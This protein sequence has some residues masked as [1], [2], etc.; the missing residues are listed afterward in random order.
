MLII[1]K[2]KEVADQRPAWVGKEATYAKQMVNTEGTPW[3]YKPSVKWLRTHLEKD[4]PKVEREVLIRE[5]HTKQGRKCL[6]CGKTLS[7]A[8]SR[9][10]SMQGVVLDHHHVSGNVRGVAH[11]GCNQ[12]EGYFWGEI[13][14]RYRV[15]NARIIERLRHDGWDA[16]GRL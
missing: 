11:S 12:H 7:L 4:G 2:L 15:D 8:K 1:E 6:Y 13:R 16:E 10:G 9:R 5:L 14:S 3:V